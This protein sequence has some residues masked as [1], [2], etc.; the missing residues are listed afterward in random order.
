MKLLFRE[1]PRPIPLIPLWLFPHTCKCGSTLHTACMVSCL[2]FS[3]YYNSG[4]FFFHDSTQKVSPL[5]FNNHNISFWFRFIKFWIRWSPLFLLRC[6]CNWKCV[7]SKIIR[8]LNSGHQEADT[9]AE[10]ETCSRFTS[11]H[12][13]QAWRPQE[14]EICLTSRCL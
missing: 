5:V 4:I 13:G 10:W 9:R 11:R 7:C 6:T 8:Y 3:T 2:P 1:A 14:A 12:R